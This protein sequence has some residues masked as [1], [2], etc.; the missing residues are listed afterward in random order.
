VSGSGVFLQTDPQPGGSC[1][2]YDYAC[3]DPINNYDLD[4]KAK[5]PVPKPQGNTL[6]TR[7]AE[8]VAR[9]LGYENVHALKS[10]FN[11][12]SKFDLIKDGNDIYLRGK[13]NVGEG[14]YVG[15]IDQETGKIVQIMKEFGGGKSIWEQDVQTFEDFGKAAEDAGE[16]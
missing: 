16:L 5:T 15:T 14:E 2:P 4:G 9:D 8:L 11:V 10:E 12:D 1:N 7:E 6:S 13:G 3:Q